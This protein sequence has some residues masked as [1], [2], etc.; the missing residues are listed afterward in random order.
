MIG[1]VRSLSSAA[2]VTEDRFVLLSRVLQLEMHCT[3]DVSATSHQEQIEV[4]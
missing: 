1:Q 3:A 4:S 2:N